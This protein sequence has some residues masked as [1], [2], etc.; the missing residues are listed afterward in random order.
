M[1]RIAWMLVLAIASAANGQV[2]KL[3]GTTSTTFKIDANG[4]TPVTITTDGSGRL[5]L[6]S[7]LRITSGTIDLTGATVSGGAIN[8]API[9]ATTASSGAFTSLSTSSQITNTVATGTA[10]MAISSTTKV[11]NLN[12]DSVDGVS[13]SAGSAGAVSYQSDSSTIAATSVGTSGQFLKSGGSG[14]PTWQGLTS[15]QLFVGDGSNLPAA[16]AMSGDATLASNGALTIASSAVTAGKL[17]DAVADE[18]TTF[19]ISAGAEDTNVI[20]VT[21]QAKDAQGNNLARGCMVWWVL[22]DATGS[23]VVTS[24]SPTIATVDGTEWSEVTAEKKYAHFTDATGKLTVDVT[25]V[26]D[27]TIQFVASVGGKV[28]SQAL[29]FD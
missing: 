10:P 22:S 9:G 16:V 25:L 3:D 28:S 12:V 18:V 5:Q 29:D 6:G 17:A 1:N 2:M 15:G 11:S 21:V 19:A 13:I 26:G 24:E 23:A 7:G 27:L 20:R 14:A 4:S 8:S